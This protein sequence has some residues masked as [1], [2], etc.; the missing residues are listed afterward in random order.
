MDGLDEVQVTTKI[1]CK[2]CG[3]EFDTYDY[4]NMMVEDM[5]Y[6]P[7]CGKKIRRVVYE[8]G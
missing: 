3:R 2:E 7:F 8:E 1:Y 5:N 4:D 6:C